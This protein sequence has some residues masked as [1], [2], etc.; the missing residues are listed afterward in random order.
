MSKSTL[1][2]VAATTLIGAVPP[3]KEGEAAGDP[4]EL[5]QGEELTKD[6]QKALGLKNEDVAQLILAGTLIETK[7]RA[8]AGSED[9]PAFAAAVRRA[10]DAEA[11][12]AAETTRADNAE[13]ALAALQKQVDE[14]AK[15]KPTGG[16]QAAE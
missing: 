7:V 11:A 4:F 13:A 2:L 1:I 15:G 16:Q 3:K 8:A 9:S 5:A 12:L 10:D 14:A 6:A